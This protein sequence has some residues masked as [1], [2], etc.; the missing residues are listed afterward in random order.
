MAPTEAIQILAAAT[1][2]GA[3]INRL[4]YVRVQAALEAL[5]KFVQEHTPKPSESEQ[6]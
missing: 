2:P 3:A 6:K 4:G 1:E 5:A